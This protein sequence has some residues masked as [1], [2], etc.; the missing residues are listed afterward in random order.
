[1]ERMV[2]DPAATSEISRLIARWR[3]GDRE[4]M[5]RVPSSACG[6]AASCGATDPRP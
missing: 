6:R 2:E 4:A 3:E 1:M 5:D